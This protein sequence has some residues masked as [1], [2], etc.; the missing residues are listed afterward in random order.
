MGSTDD[1]G[2]L[3]PATV[4]TGYLDRGTDRNKWCTSVRVALERGQLS[5][6]ETCHLR[7]SDEPGQW[8]EPI[9]IELGVAGDT[10]PVVEF[11]GLGTYRRRAWRFEFSAATDLVLASVTEEF[12]VLGQ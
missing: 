7:Y 2:D 11:R 12:E 4:E 8:S 10:Y 1:L 5:T 9:E 6:A 3:V